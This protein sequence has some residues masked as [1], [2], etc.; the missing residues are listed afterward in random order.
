MRAGLPMSSKQ[1]YS[2]HI[3]SCIQAGNCLQAGCLLDHVHNVRSAKQSGTHCII[4]ALSNMLAPV[5]GSCRNGTCMQA[6]TQLHQL[7]FAGPH[8]AVWNPELA[9]RLK[10]L[11]LHSPPGNGLPGLRVPGGVDCPLTLFAAQRAAPAHTT[12]PLPPCRRGWPACTRCYWYL[13][14]YQPQAGAAFVVLHGQTSA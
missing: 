4:S 9:V 14:L 11:I 3:Y 8:A 6:M 5:F 13:C 10:R 12:P 1:L 2:C 7:M